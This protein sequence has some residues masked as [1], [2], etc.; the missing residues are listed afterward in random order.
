M[1]HHQ[2]LERQVTSKQQVFTTLRQRYEEARIQEVNDT[3]V[4]TRI[5]LAVPPENKSSPQ[6]KVWVVLAFIFGGGIGLVV[7]FSREF[8]ER[9]RNRQDGDFQEFTSRW[10]TI[11][12]EIRF[13]FSR[14]RRS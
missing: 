3:P 5:D 12:R 4:I 11:K 14:E 13:P 1:F 2:R 8:A 9:A 6:R 10:A 7:G